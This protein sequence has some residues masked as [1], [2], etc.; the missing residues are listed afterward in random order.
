MSPLYIG[1]LSGTSMDAVDAALVRC[2]DDSA[3]L[4][5]ALAYPIPSALRQRLQA[6]VETPNGGNVDDLCALDLAL[7]DL[8]AETAL[9]LLAR[10]GHQPERIRAIGSHGQTIRHRPLGL[11][12]TVQLGDPNRIAYRT[13][14]PTVADFR[15]ADLAAGGQGAPLASSLHRAL[16]ATPGRTRAIVNIG[17]V[18]NITVL[19]GTDRVIGFDTGPGNGLMDAWAAKTLDAP[20]DADGAAAESGKAD[21]GLMRAM[22]RH[23]FIAR[24]PPKSTGRDEFTERWL[25]EILDHHGATQSPTDVMA[26]LNLLTA[27]SIADA[28][29]RWAPEAKEVAVCGGGARNPVLMRNLRQSMPERSV[30]TTQSLGLDPDWVEAVAFAWL[31]AKRL[32]GAPGNLPEVTGASAAVVLGG[33]YAPMPGHRRRSDGE[34]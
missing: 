8:L 11:A 18:A 21:A 31:A 2:A 7:G 23:P 14:I 3:E 9:A 10:S 26:T 22:L 15:R 28:L 19:Y 33:V 20:F 29:S 24:P 16:W 34:R 27:R 30:G 12:T 25:E 32:A 4:L 17:G 6:V 13:G 1:L 5:Y